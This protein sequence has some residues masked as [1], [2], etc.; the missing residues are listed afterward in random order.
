LYFFAHRLKVTPV[1]LRILYRTIKMKLQSLIILLGVAALIAC[2]SNGAHKTLSKT[3]NESQTTVVEYIR[4]LKLKQPHRGELF[5]KGDTIEIEIH[6]RKKAEDI[7][8][9]QLLVDG[10]LTQT[11]NAKPWKFSHIE[12]TDQMGKHSFQLLAYHEDGKIGNMISYYNIKSDLVPKELTYKI[13]NTFP[14]DKKSYTQGLFFHDGYLYEGTGQH[15]E[16]ALL[17]VDIKTGKSVFDRKLESKYFGE[18]IA[19]YTGNIIQLTWRSE[20]AFVIDADDFSQKDYFRPPT[21]NGQGWGITCMNNKL[22]ISDGSNKLTLVDPK[23]YG[24]TGDIEVYDEKG[25]VTNLNEL[26]YINGKIYANVWLTDRIVVINP[27][28]GQVEGNLNLE[29]IL[30]AKEKRHLVKGDDVLNGIAYDSINNRLFV[31]GKRW[32]KLLEI[33]ID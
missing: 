1:I 21:T 27:S 11:I 25:A 2:N 18:G 33:K 9:L 10:E 23:N 20:K 29:N 5:T 6:K 22:L 4:S 12:N 3:E 13:I 16:S 31:T 7:D 14:H 17:K 30:S 28:T 8:S 32:S 15:G 26:E 24:K 19:Y